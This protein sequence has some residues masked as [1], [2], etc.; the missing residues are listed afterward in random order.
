MAPIFYTSWDKAGG[1]TATLIPLFY[2]RS[3]VG[4]MAIYT[5]LFGVDRSP[6]RRQY[7]VGP[8]FRRRSD[9]RSLDILVPLF[10]R[11]RNHIKG[12]TTLLTIPYYGRWSKER[13][14]HLLFPLYWRQRRIDRSNTVVFPFYWDF[15][16]RY[17]SR[18]S[19]FFPLLLYHR[20]HAA[21]STSIFT[22][23]GIWLRFRP[24]A[25]DSV[26]FPLFWHFGGKKRSTTLA[27]PLYY[28]FKRHR[29]RTTIFFPLFW[30]FA[31]GDKSTTFVVNTLYMKN[32]REKTYNLVI[33]PLLQVQ[34]KRPQ[35]IKVEALGGIFGYERV[36]RNRLMTI[37]FY[38]FPLEPTGA[39]GAPQQKVPRQKAPQRKNPPKKQSSVGSPK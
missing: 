38:T 10:M 22:P 11:Y 29:K 1:K 15:D 12:Q 26:V 14:F 28:D 20:N 25:T 27:L 18:T 35:D 37:L 6:L 39:R 21:K 30:R 17:S 32:S 23:P 9:E 3:E 4:R 8:Y 19:I 13:S 5:P 24:E 2:Y 7:Y 16:N 33:I 36:G 34:R 31:K